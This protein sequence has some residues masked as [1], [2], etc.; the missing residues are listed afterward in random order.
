LIR[1]N[2]EWPPPWTAL[3][4]RLGVA[5]KMSITVGGF[6]S[7]SYALAESTRSRILRSIYEMFKGF[8]DRAITAA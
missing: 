4:N 3:S 7:N 8:Y 1:I 6:S 5:G 2:A